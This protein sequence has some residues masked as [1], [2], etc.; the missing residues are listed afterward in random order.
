MANGKALGLLLA[1]GGETAAVVLL[2]RKA[3]AKET[4]VVSGYLQSISASTTLAQLESVRNQFEPLGVQGIITLA[5]WDILWKAYLAKYAI[6][7]SASP[8][9][10]PPPPPPITPTP[11]GWDGR[12]LPTT[13]QVSKAASMSELN[14]MRAVF[15]AAWQNYAVTGMT[16]ELYLALFDAYVARYAV[17]A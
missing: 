2:T 14:A 6:L 1:A 11:S 15:E 13:V 10:V 12:S 9:P 3:A 16:Y 17:L 4:P 8:I 7:A 5:E